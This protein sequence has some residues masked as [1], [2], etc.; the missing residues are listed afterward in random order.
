MPPISL[1]SCRERIL[2][3]SEGSSSSALGKLRKGGGQRRE[4]KEWA[5]SDDTCS[6]RGEKSNEDTGH[7]KV[8]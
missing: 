1:Y 3:F 7:S 6:H 5:D 4:Q 8:C 2:L